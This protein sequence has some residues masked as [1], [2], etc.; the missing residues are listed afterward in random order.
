[1]LVFVKLAVGQAVQLDFFI[2]SCVLEDWP[3]ATGVLVWY[4]VV[5]SVSVVTVYVHDF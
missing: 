3:Q 5:R 2:F 1:M 4:P